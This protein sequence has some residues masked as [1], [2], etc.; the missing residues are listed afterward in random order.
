MAKTI[1]SF[2][3]NSRTGAGA[4][5]AKYN[6]AEL[7]NGKIW[8]LVSGDDYDCPA[9]GCQASLRAA[10]R[11][12]GIKLRVGSTMLDGKEAVVLQAIGAVDTPATEPNV[13]ARSNGVAPAAAPA[14]DTPAADTAAKKP[15]RRGMDA[16]AA[17]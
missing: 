15:R 11:R 8:A 13:D 5:G 3:F 4:K 10:G 1:E 9:K 16:A 2:E 7:F 6:Y 17:A 14:A 12:R